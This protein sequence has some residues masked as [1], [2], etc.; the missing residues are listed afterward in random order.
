LTAPRDGIVVDDPVTVGSTLQPGQPFVE[1]YDPTKLTFNGQVSLV[2]LPQIG[3]GMVATLRAVG[4]K[5]SVQATVQRVVPRV[6]NNQVDVSPDHLKVVLLPKNAKDMAG[7]V[8]GVRFTGTV[9][10]STGKPGIQKLI[11]LGG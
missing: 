3:P 10:T 7:L 9:D 4:L 11:Y 5:R 6:G 8:P 2:D 1:L